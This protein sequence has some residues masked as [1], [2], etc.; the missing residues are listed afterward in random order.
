M[1][2]GIPWPTSPTS[3]L[4]PRS[5]HLHPD[6]SPRL[7]GHSTYLTMALVKYP[8]LLPTNRHFRLSLTLTVGFQ[9][10]CFTFRTLCPN[11]TRTLQSPLKTFLL[12]FLWEIRILTD[13]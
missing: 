13:N 2:S 9:S 7:S 1:S 3:Q 4:C 8:E 10:H 11:L 6:T 12:L 5:H